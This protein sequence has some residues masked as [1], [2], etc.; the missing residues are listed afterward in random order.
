MAEVKRHTHYEVIKT[1]RDVQRLWEMIEETHKVFT[2]GHITLVV[3]KTAHKE[4][5]L[6]HQGHT[7]ASL[8]TRN[9]S[10]LPLR[11]FKIRRMPNWISLIE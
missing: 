9:V 2:I 5:P 1:N 8:L 10:M 6:M 3:K 4:Y 11:L 7:K